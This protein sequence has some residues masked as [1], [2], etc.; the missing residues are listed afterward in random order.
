MLGMLASDG[1][2]GL[3]G[4]GIYRPPLH[5]FEELLALP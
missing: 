3:C 5:L 1:R 4:R 2:H